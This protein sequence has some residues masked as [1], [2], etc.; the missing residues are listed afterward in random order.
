MAGPP[1]LSTSTSL[2]SGVAANAGSTVLGKVA[3]GNA[4]APASVAVVT[5]PG[6]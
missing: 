2:P 4:R 6:P 1:G 5:P 3:S